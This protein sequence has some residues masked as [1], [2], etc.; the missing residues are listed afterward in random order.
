MLPFLAIFPLGQTNVLA[1]NAYEMLIVSGTLT[2]EDD[3]LSFISGA[4]FQR[5]EILTKWK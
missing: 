4:I 3:I 2:V 5:E 1:P